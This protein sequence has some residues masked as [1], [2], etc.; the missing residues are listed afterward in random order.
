MKKRRGLL[1][2]LGILFAVS[3][4]STVMAADLQ[5]AQQELV[6]ETT[7]FSETYPTEAAP[8]IQE[9]KWEVDKETSKW[10][11][12]ID[13]QV[14]KD[15]SYQFA[16]NIYYVKDGVLVTGSFEVVA[17]PSLDQGHHAIKES[18]IYYF[19]ETGA[20]PNQGLGVMAK[21]EVWVQASDGRW[22][23]ADAQGKLDY[24][25]TGLQN[26]DGKTFLLDEKGM[27]LKGVHKVEGKSYY[28]DET[29]GEKQSYT[30][31]K[32][33]DGQ[34][35][36]FSET[37]EVTVSQESGWKE[38]DGLRY[39]LEKG[40]VHTG[41]LEDAEKNYYFDPADGHMMT[42][43][44]YISGSWF[45]LDEA[46]GVMATGWTEVGGKKYLLSDSGVLQGGWY[47][48]GSHWYYLDPMT[49]AMHTG[50][51]N[52]NGS[53][54]YMSEDGI[55]QGGWLNLDGIWYYL[56]P[57]SGALHTGWTNVGGANYY[58]NPATGAMHTGWNFIN[59]RWYYL[60]PVN[61]VMCTGWVSIDGTWYYMN[62]EGVLQGG[63]VKVD[64]TWYYTD[65][66]T[67]AMQIGW[68]YVG[69]SW[70]FLHPGSGAMNIGWLRIN[71]TWYYTNSNGALQG[72]W[73]NDGGTWYYMDPN[74]GAMHT[75]WE[76]LNGSWYYLDP[77]NG[78]MRTGWVKV[79]TFWYYMYSNGAMASDTWV[80]NYYVD[81]SGKWIPNYN[82][83]TYGGHWEKNDGY[84][85]FRKADGGYFKNRMMT[86]EGQKYLFEA[87]GRMAT[88]W[89]YY[90]G[91]KYY[92]DDN[93]H[94]V[95]DLDNVI[96][97]Q[98]SYYISLNRA[99]CQVTIFAKDGANGYIIPAKTLTCSVG[100]PNT[101]TPTGTFSL[102]QKY[103]WKM[104]M[105]PSYGQY[106][107]R[108][109]DGIYFHSVAGSNMTSYNLDPHQYN[110]LGSPA[111]HGCVR[112]NVR[113]AK[114]LYDNVPSGTTVRVSD[115]EPTPFDKPATIKIPAN[116]NWD[117]TDPAI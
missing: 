108:F 35:Y 90:N 19:G 2:S 44:T 89:K 13:G 1:I 59:N 109:T 96:G 113:D 76:L 104:L 4:G 114:W 99:K 8:K 15:G 87:D 116:Q 95:Q 24:S 48:D 47:H 50:W 93:G 68:V 40:K 30:G 58:L 27:P 112:L 98:S 66:T 16:D 51:V 12:K 5:Q 80:G 42:G 74:S 41:W 32:V 31:W 43:W 86:I 61:G 11:L 28:F 7:D 64:G 60:N 6:Q 37:S 72:G 71:T 33:I 65:P 91:Y 34:L 45:Y 77:S 82:E 26:I 92:F 39:Y 46:T 3:T 63:W 75:G 9:L 81:D 22:L 85:Y 97:R 62:E 111:S 52:V 49:G 78:A 23:F 21:G 73:L 57:T 117:P 88:G 106:S 67:G 10:T 38:I 14:A 18:G 69:G 20:D 103:R 100:M 94:M 110:L 17:D 36:S 83:T 105:G 101:P 79:G 107:I 84:W 115:S 56:N 102:G 70:Y 55:M 25:K 54:H 53:L 29:T